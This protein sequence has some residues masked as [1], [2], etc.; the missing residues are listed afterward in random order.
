MFCTQCGNK[1]IE[2]DRFCTKCGA[3][4]EVFAAAAETVS[5]HAAGQMPQPIEQMPQP[6][7][8]VPQ[9]IEQASQV[10]EAMPKLPPGGQKSV[11]QTV[12]PMQ[13]L[14]R[15]GQTSVPQAF[16]PLQASPSG[17]QAQAP[18][19]NG[20]AN[21]LQPIVQPSIPKSDAAVQG[22]EWLVKAAAFMKQRKVSMDKED[23]F[24]IAVFVLVHATLWLPW[25]V[26]YGRWG[27]TLRYTYPYILR[28]AMPANV[29]FWFWAIQ[30]GSMACSI[31]LYVKEKFRFSLWLFWVSFVPKI[32]CFMGLR[33]QAGVNVTVFPSVAIVV[34]AICIGVFSKHMLHKYM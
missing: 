5:P 24:I 33:G 22:N 30:L 32:L 6:T 13:E 18:R 17:G 21:V 34:E 2:G 29:V 15:D 28:E 27:Q 14:P 25:I 26:L 7:G 31:V 11:A 8:Q 3:R 4:L 20:Q 23:A 10:V 1:V 9:P 19:L 16:E 12:L